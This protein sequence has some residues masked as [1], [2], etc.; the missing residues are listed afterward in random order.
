MAL[1]F[2]K[3]KRLFDSLADNGVRWTIYFVVEERLRFLAN[4]LSVQKKKLEKRYALPGTN[5]IPRNYQTWQEYDW[6]KGGEEWN[7]SLE[8]KQSLI[9]EVLL[10]WITPGKTVLEIGPGGGRWTEA[11]QGISTRLILVDLSD[12]CIE[13]CKNKFSGCTNIDYYVNDGSSLAFIP[14]SSVDFIWSFDVFVHINPRDTEKYIKEF[15]RILR[16]RGRGI[17]H[18]GNKDGP[19]WWW[20]SSLTADRFSEMVNKSGLRLISQFDSWGS[21]EHRGLRYDILEVFEK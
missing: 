4:A 19:H 14:N 16:K 8:W 1:F 20:R 10:K 6:S 15:A 11:L 13:Q 17:I 9:D 3:L 21:G 2:R 12:K 7:R 18:H 5:T